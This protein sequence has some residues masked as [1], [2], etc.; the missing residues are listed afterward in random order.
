MA[1]AEA[2]QHVLT[3]LRYKIIGAQQAALFEFHPRH[4]LFAAANR[5]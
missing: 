2:L 1:Q 3:Q 4:M 5:L